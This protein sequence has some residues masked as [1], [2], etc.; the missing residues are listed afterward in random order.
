MSGIGDQGMMPRHVQPQESDDDTMDERVTSPPDA[1]DPAAATGRA[2]DVP[3][4]DGAGSR[5]QDEVDEVLAGISDD[6]RA[7]AER[8]ARNDRRGQAADDD[9]RSQR[10]P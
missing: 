7:D 8:L 6:E 3:H 4:R 10:N 2:D 9:S 5:E 1:E